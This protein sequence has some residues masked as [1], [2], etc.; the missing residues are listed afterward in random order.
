MNNPKLQLD[1]QNRRALLV[2][3][4]VTIALFFI[5]FFAVSELL[6]ATQWQGILGNLIT[7]TMSA[8]SAI[9]TVLCWRGHRFVGIRLLLGSLMGGMLLITILV[10][11]Y[12]FL[13]AVI[14]V[15][16]TSLIAVQTLPTQESN[17]LSLVSLGG[18]VLI[19]AIDTLWSG[20]R[21]AANPQIRLIANWTTAIVLLAYA[22]M[23]LRQFP[24]YKLRTKLSITFI[25]AA[26]LAA[27]S[28]GVV[29][30]TIA[31]ASLTRQVEN[32]ISEIAEG[33]GTQIGELI[34][35]NLQLIQTLALNRLVQASA[36]TA[37][38]EG[39]DDQEVLEQ[40]D[41]QWRAADEVGNN[42]DPLVSKVLQH[43]LALELR[44]FRTSFPNHAEVFITD[45][46]G[47][48]IASTNRTSDYYQADEE[49]WQAAYNA[50]FGSV[51]IGQPELDQSANIIA[52]N[53]ALP[54][55]HREKP[56]I[57][58]I[59]RT[60]LDITLIQQLLEEAEFGETGKISLRF[61]E[62]QFLHRNT[63]ENFE[64]LSLETI[65][66]LNDLGIGSGQVEF[67]GIPTFASQA[68]VL[69]RYDGDASQ[70]A[71]Y[72]EE[73]GWFVIVH[74]DQTEALQP[75][76]TI[77][78]SIILISLG[79]MFVVG[80]LAV[81]VAQRLAT[82]IVQLTEVAEKI[83]S[84]DLNVEA[85]IETDDEIG[86][87][88]TTINAMTKQ[89]QNLIGS[90]E[91]QVADRTQALSTSAEVSRRLSTIL[92]P[93]QLVKEVVEQVQQAFD[94]YHAH[95]YLFDDSREKLLMAGGTGE[96]GRTMLANQ[97][98][99]TAGRGLV[100][101]AADT[102]QVVLVPDTEADPNWL[103]NPLLPD[104]KS[105][106]AVPIAIGSYVLGVLDVQDN[107]AGG[108]KQEDAELLQAVANQVA[109]A[110][111]NA[112]AYEQVQR[113]ATRE[114]RVVAINQ[115]IQL[116]TTIDDVLRVAVR[117]LGQALEVDRFVVEL[118]LDAS[119]N[120]G[121]N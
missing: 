112:K 69:A 99:I 52:M 88:A 34:D 47:A 86:V 20:E 31:Q 50:G 115:Q 84:G 93:D 118:N 94:Y 18:G 114:A 49:W 80:T 62:N 102:N 103:P 8:L 22:G 74:Q 61:P 79:V 90:L 4:L 98:A 13:A 121:Q 63:T 117:E 44:E 15:I 19:I 83:R 57:V 85:R 27:G 113:R 75:V 72:V 56:E 95:I 3:L 24:N 2:T 33:R 39:T 17:R 92:E 14:V 9:S 111:Q 76:T 104:T 48:N 100:G 25:I 108:L 60:T 55:F 37:A 101:R 96:A 5:S 12:G 11:G 35:A 78:R 54:I 82:P 36:E 77:T 71:K 30:N 38:L 46:Y 67:F 45:K 68:P 120:G 40:L 87:L 58:G 43:E 32:N 53:M 1:E 119:S 21:I 51:Y 26:L 65:L 97:H 42:N 116:A 64:V 109:I 23:T 7:P 29:T 91:Q 110:I 28:V 66:A 6:K 73:L 59:I 41:Q 81:F 70:G 105:E 107:I 16:V 106:V 10:Q 89:L